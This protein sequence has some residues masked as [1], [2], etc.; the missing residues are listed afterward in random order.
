MI[1]AELVLS[2]CASF[3][4]LRDLF[5]FTFV[6]V[7]V[8]FNG[9]YMFSYTCNL[10]CH[11][12]FWGTRRVKRF[13]VHFCM[14]CSTRSF[15]LAWEAL[16]PGLAF[17]DECDLL[18]GWQQ[19]W[20]RLL[21]LRESIYLITKRAFLRVSLSG[22]KLDFRPIHEIKVLRPKSSHPSGNWDKHS[23]DFFSFLPQKTLFSFLV[24][25]FKF[26]FIYFRLF[27]FL[28][29]ISFCFLFFDSAPS[30]LVIFEDM[31][32]RSARNHA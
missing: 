18:T 16:L 8:R 19:P 17:I 24:L 25:T 4:R 6:F 22:R 5:T 12:A 30:P 28:K 15:F 20:T 9:C 11:P 29:S 13:T 10:V 7:F 3:L 2:R 26:D 32:K 31:A 23:D 14:Q 1:F 21:G 27:F